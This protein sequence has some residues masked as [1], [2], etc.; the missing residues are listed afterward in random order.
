[1]THK[2]VK[3]GPVA[4][5]DL[6]N[7]V[8]ANSSENSLYTLRAQHLASI[9]KLPANTAIVVAELAFGEVRS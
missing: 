2:A 7:S 4:G 5:T 3:A 6:R 8:L 9:F 1:M